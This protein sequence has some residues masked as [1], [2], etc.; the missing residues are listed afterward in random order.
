MDDEE[1]RK[2]R[3]LTRL[4][5]VELTRPASRRP[6][7]TANQVEKLMSAT[8]VI[9]RLGNGVAGDTSTRDVEIGIVRNKDGSV[10]VL[11]AATV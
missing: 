6:A 10:V 3:V 5:N 8:N 1:L 4:A 7:F 2:G 11:P 9:R